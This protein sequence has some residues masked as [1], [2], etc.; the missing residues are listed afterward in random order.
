MRRVLATLLVA[1]VLVAGA[2]SAAAQEGE[3]D[4]DAFVPGDATTVPGSPETTVPG[5]D[6]TA[7]PTTVSNEPTTTALPAGCSPPPV[8]HAVFVG[9][10]TAFDIRTARFEVIELRSGSLSGFQ[11]GKLVDVDFFDDHRYL[12]QGAEYLV[13]AGVDDATGRLTSKAKASLPRFGGDQVVGVND[14]NVA[15]PT[16]D[17]PLISRMADGSSIES[18][19]VA[20]MIH[21]KG[22][23]LRAFLLPAGVAFAALVLIVAVKRSFSFLLRRFRRWWRHRRATAGLASR[24]A[25]RASPAP[26]PR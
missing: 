19:V 1:L 6:T 24:R 12:E 10:L 23:I 5:A 26:Q 11:V 22:R 25:R 2:G 13:A 17:D 4:G 9:R 18:G 16:F 3:G 8:P 7:P 15:C 21:A 20:P 14:R